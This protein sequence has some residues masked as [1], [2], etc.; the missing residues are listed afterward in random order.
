MQI[1]N[2]WAINNVEHKNSYRKKAKFDE[3]ASI[4]KKAFSKKKR[5]NKAAK[6]LSTKIQ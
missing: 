6:R 1:Y 4:L 3:S 5:I 2:Y